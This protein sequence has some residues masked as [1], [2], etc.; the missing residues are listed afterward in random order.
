MVT[1]P[2]WDSVHSWVVPPSSSSVR[3]DRS[4]KKFVI[5]FVIVCV[6]VCVCVCDSSCDST[7]GSVP[8]TYDPLTI[9]ATSL[10]FHLA[11]L[12][13]DAHGNTLVYI[14]IYISR[15]LGVRFVLV[16]RL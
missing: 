1:F 7:V 16:V 15:S 11:S 12:C 14:Y 3:C 9:V 10:Q 4:C 8:L 2:K 13:A 6:C 5:V